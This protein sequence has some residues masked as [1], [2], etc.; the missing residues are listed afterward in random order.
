MAKTVLTAPYILINAVDYSTIVKS[1]ELNI[2]REQL[3]AAAGGDDTAIKKLGL[4]NITLRVNF[5]QDYADNGL[6]EK[7]FDI[8]N[9]EVAVALELRPSTDAVGVTNPSYELNVVLPDYAPLS[10]QHGAMIMTSPTFV[11]AGSI[12]RAVA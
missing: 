8:W 12:T 9:A 4:R 11:A 7:L 10:A 2:T 5:F 6:D 3:D 1:V